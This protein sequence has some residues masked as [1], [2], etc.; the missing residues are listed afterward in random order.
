MPTM[1]WIWLAAFVIFLIME[2]LSPTMIF[3]GFAVGAFISGIVSLFYPEAHYWQIGI[4]IAVTVMVLPLTRK[5]V[6]KITSESPSESNVD[7]M[8]DNVA[9][10][11]AAID[12]DRGGKVKY[13]GEVW[14]A[15]ADE[16]ID[17][18]EKVIIKSVIGTK[19]MV[20][21]ITE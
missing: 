7:A 4:F 3:L 18:N 1:V 2:I 9:I 20:E 17:V 14:R 21:R 11:T 6:K 19:V 5:F 13:E 8:L 15:V 12:P 16:A 10:V